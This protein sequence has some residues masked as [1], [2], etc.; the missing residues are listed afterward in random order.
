M[1]TA[2]T[3]LATD[4]FDCAR[5]SILHN[6]QKTYR[7]FSQHATRN[8]PL[9][10]HRTTSAY[11]HPNNLT[12][13]SNWVHNNAQEAPSATEEDH[14]QR[15]LSSTLESLHRLQ[16]FLRPFVQGSVKLLRANLQYT[17]G[18]APTLCASQAG[19]IGSELRRPLISSHHTCV[20]P[21]EVSPPICC[22]I[23][24]MRHL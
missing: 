3:S 14:R 19:G 21:L 10:E 16:F 8:R 12:K 11:C 15:L 13:F 20:V 18:R 17:V 4:A 7:I 6:S 1:R 9:D 2:P 23:H 5:I 24:D 22:C